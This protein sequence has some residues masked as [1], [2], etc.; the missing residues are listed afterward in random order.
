MHKLIR[1]IVYAKS[2][3]EAKDKAI[4]V[5][6]ESLSSEVY[7]QFDWYVMHGKGTG[8]RWGPLNEAY[9]A[10]SVRGKRL[11]DEAMKLTRT[12]FNKD[13]D[14]LR[15]I[16]K[17][18]IENL[19][20]NDMFRFYCGEMNVDH[21]FWL[22]DQDGEPIYTEDHLMRCLNKWQD[23]YKDEDNPFEDLNIYVVPID[24]HH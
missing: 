8:A 11:I 21:T 2:I 10:E 15:E 6:E 4:K 12:E 14:K 24:A 16:I 18:S 5:M 23:V 1:I 17:D 13:V 3:N 20:N 9:K 19:F 7:G 22:F